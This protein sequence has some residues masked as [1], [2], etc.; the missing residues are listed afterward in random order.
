MSGHKSGKETNAD[1]IHFIEVQMKK[2]LSDKKKT[3]FKDKDEA[4]KITSKIIYVWNETISAEHGKLDKL[5]ESEKREWFESIEIAF[6]DQRSKFEY[7]DTITDFGIFEKNEKNLK[8]IFDEIFYFLPKNAGTLMLFATPILELEAFPPE[9]FK[10]IL[11][12]KKPDEN[13]KELFRK[14]Y[15]IVE[16]VMASF[17]ETNNKKSEELIARAVILAEEKFQHQR[18]INIIE[19]IYN[20]IL[21]S[22]GAGYDFDE[23]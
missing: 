10:Q 18:A 11:S 8:L 15:K 21:R 4:Q 3:A 7:R 1:I 13:E 6:A 22:L 23:I 19:K 20:D 2:Y 9:R 12:G 17:L 5:S 14:A 16:L